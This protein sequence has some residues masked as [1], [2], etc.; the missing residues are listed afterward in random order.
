MLAI[1]DYVNERKVVTIG[2]VCSSHRISEFGDDYIYRIIASEDNAVKCDTDIMINRGF[3]RIAVVVGAHEAGFSYE[4]FAK[5]MLGEK[6]LMSIRLDLTKGDWRSELTTIKAANPDAILFNEIWV[7]NAKILLRQADEIGLD[8][9]TQGF[10]TFFDPEIFKEPR[11]AEYMIKTGMLLTKPTS[12]L[13]LSYELF[14]RKFEEIRGEKPPL[15]AD[16]YYDGVMLAALAISKA[17]V[18]EGPAIK[19]SLDFIGQ[20]GLFMGASDYLPMDAKGDVRWARR[21]IA[22]VVKENGEY[23]FKNVGYWDPFEGVKWL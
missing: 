18:Y 8:V 2:T 3:K 15:Y 10:E 14:E 5:E 17:G 6:F 16:K 11:A 1:A 7:D 20:G 21:I 22:K 9:P 23:K 19:K 12:T 13:P 4:K